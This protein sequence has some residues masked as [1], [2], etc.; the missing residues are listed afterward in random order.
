MLGGDVPLKFPEAKSRT[1]EGGSQLTEEHGGEEV[2]GYCILLDKLSILGDGNHPPRPHVHSI[3]APGYFK[4]PLIFELDEI[5]ATVFR[6]SFGISF[7]PPRQ[8]SVA[9]AKPK[10]IN[11]KTMSWLR[12]G[13]NKIYAE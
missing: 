8:Q 4:S 13:F 5:S 11:L 3:F 1:Q 9:N 7:T 2:R 12:E 6:R 10:K